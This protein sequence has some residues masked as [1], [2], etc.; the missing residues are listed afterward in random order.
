MSK[1]CDN[2]PWSPHRLHKQTFTL[3]QSH[4][5]RWCR[6]C[7]F[8]FA[9]LPEP[10]DFHDTDLLQRIDTCA[11]HSPSLSRPKITS[12]FTL[13]FSMTRYCLHFSLL[14]NWIIYAEVF[15]CNGCS[16]YPF[17]RDSGLGQLNWA[18]FMYSLFASS[19]YSISK[20][21]LHMATLVTEM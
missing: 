18:L 1:N 20:V 11:A 7:D 12:P 4:K 14:E 17:Q 9:S 5:V 13:D 2:Q 15:L 3:R 16:S 21:S 10:S 8:L 6:L 19:K